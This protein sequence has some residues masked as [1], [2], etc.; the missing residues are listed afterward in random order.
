MSCKIIITT[1]K[2]IIY[3][4]EAFTLMHLVFLGLDTDYIHFDFKFL[5]ENNTAVIPS[6]FH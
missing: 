1:Q 2:Q 5:D 3:Y 4:E 6:K